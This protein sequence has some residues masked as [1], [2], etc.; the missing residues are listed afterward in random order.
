VIH[1]I[2][3]LKDKNH[4]IISLDMEKAFD[5]IQHPFMI[6]VLGRSGIQGP[7]LNMIKAIYSKPVANIKVNGEKLEAIPLKSGTRQGCPLSPYLFNIVLEVLARAIPQQKEI[8]EIQFG[9]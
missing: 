1:Y 8:K 5:K 2:N 9:K 6:K 7:Y 3:K 4:M